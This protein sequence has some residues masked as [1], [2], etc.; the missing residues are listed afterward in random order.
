MV[1]LETFDRTHRDELDLPWNEF[2][3]T[4]SKRLIVTCLYTFTLSAVCLIIEIAFWVE[5][6]WRSKKRSGAIT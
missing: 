5:E 3:L 6:L 2:A 4:P 1:C